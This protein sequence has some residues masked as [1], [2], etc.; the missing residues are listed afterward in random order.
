MARLETAS[1]LRDGLHAVRTISASARVQVREQVAAETYRFTAVFQPLLFAALFV[2]VYSAT[3][4][5]ELLPFALVSGGAV[6]MWNAS[7]WATALFLRDER[8]NGTLPLL[9]SARSS[10]T[11]ICFGKV[12][13]GS[14][15]AVAP[16][17]L[18]AGA[19]ALAF[20]QITP[21]ALGALALVLTGSVFSMACLVLAIAP[22][23]ILSRAGA[24][25]AN[26]LNYPFFILAGAFLPPGTLPAT[27]STVG[28]VLPLMWAIKGLN[29]LVGTV[30]DLAEAVRSALALGLLGLVYLGIAIS[31]FRV[32][33]MQARRAGG[34]DLI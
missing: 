25:I 28:S 30:P 19:S 18:A 5:R 22:V 29:S 32:T 3:G 26:V 15:L 20:G 8:R 16:I 24:S 31:V 4:R 34:T 13:G 1:R 9:V 6:G 21:V 10:L 17:G 11:M 27:V 23:F 12:L 7:L 33:E 14:L 2:G